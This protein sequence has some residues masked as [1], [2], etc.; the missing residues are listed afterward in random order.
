MKKE[1]AIFAGGCFWCLEEVFID[2]PGVL[3]V[4]SG[5]VGGHVENPTYGEVCSGTTGH[6]EGVELYFDPDR[7]SYEDILQIFWRS[8]DPTDEQGQFA[9]RGPQYT[10]AVFAT[11]E[12]QFFQ[13]KESRKE[14]D[15]SG[16]FERPVVTEIKT[17]SVFWPAETYHQ[18]FCKTNPDRYRSYKE[19][20]G[21]KKFLESHW[22]HNSQ[23][24]G[25]TDLTPLQRK[26]ALEG[27][28]EPPFQNEYW[29]T[30]AEGIYVDIRTGQPLFASVHK[31]DSGT[32]WPSFFDAIDRERIITKKDRSLGVERVEIR[33]REGDIHLGHVFDDG[34]EP[35]KKRYCVNSASLE[36]IPRKDMVS[37]GYEEYVTLFDPE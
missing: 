14:L 8:I 6:Y 10:T 35:T 3:K 27:G 15:A 20:S 33:S 32:G 9:D 26:V 29:N 11:T 34:P 37:R 19:G 7:I 18:G 23:R 2:K 28:T 22:K 12:E 21:R 25:K 5:Y 24:P 4:T 16:L 36:F 1:R 30:K 17:A 13:A 31:Y